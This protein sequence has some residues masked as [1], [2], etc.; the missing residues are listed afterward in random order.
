MRRVLFL[1]FIATALPPGAAY[2]QGGNP[3]GP[4]FRVNTFTT[5]I[6]M[7]PSVAGDSLGGFVVTWDSNEQDGENLGVYGQRYSNGGAPLGPEFRV[8]SYTTGDQR[9]SVKSKIKIQAEAEK[10]RN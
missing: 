5:N 4:E 10:P 6:Q 9:D 2:A 7:V 1:V 8:N 3:L